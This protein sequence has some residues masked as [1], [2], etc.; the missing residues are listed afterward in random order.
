M[1]R[2]RV[3]WGMWAVALLALTVAGGSQ[4]RA[5]DPIETVPSQTAAAVYIQ[6]WGQILWGLVTNQTGTQPASFGDPIFNP[7]G[8]VTQSFTAADG[9]QAVMTFY[10]DGSVRIDITLPNGVTQTI[11]QAPPTFDGVSRTTTNWTVSSSG[12][13]SVN[14]TSIVDDRETW[15]DISDDTTQLAGSAVLPGSLTQTFTALTAAGRTDLQSTQSDGAT[16]TLSVP[17]AFPD[18]VLPDFSQEASGTYSDP[19]FAMSL[20]LTSTPAN[21]SRWAALLFD[22]GGGLTGTFSLNNDFSGF[23]QLDDSSLGAQTLAALV[24]WTQDGDVQVYL[25]SG[26]DFHMGPAG[27]ALDFLRYRWETLTA[28]LAPAPGVSRFSGR[29]PRFREMPRLRSGRRNAPR[30]LRGTPLRLSPTRARAA[31]TRVPS[32]TGAGPRPD[33]RWPVSPR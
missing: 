2:T 18:F 26:Q 12:G 1:G 32:P 30:I 17:L 33:S 19:G 8:S 5:S 4:G 6:E 11:L 29:L 27:A 28:L 20:R 23:G 24:S 22:L 10:A 31:S 7:D 25:L 16:F 15:W 13:L 14:Y 9:T 3:R 21:P